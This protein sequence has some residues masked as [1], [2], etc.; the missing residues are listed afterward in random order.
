MLDETLTR[1]KQKMIG[2][3]QT[4]RA[5][6]R[7]HERIQ[8]VYIAVD[9][10]AHVLRPVISL[11]QTHHIRIIRVPTMRELGQA[12]GIEVGAATVAILKE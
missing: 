12:C 7:E 6:E 11:C 3:K 10:E 8:S 9:A 5:L 2:L 4:Q 1:A